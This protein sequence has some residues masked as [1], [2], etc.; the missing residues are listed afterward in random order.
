MGC[1]DVLGFPVGIVGCA[2]LSMNRFIFRVSTSTAD[3]RTIAQ[4]P[5]LHTD[6][7]TCREDKEHMKTN[8]ILSNG[9][10]R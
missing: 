10:I 8:S 2:S 5:C 7:E 1:L 3:I 9:A 4:S 6:N